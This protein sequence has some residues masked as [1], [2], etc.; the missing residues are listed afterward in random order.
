MVRVRV[1]LAILGV[2]SA[3][4]LAGCSGAEDAA[5]SA[6]EQTGTSAV[7]ATPLAVTALAPPPDSTEQVPTT[8]APPTTTLTDVQFE[9]NESYYFTTPDGNFQCAVIKLPTRIEAGCEGV[10]TPVPPRPDSCMINWGNAIRVTD[11]DDV[12]FMCSGG[13][14]YTSGGPSADPVLA[15]GQPLS[16]LGFTCTTTATDVSCVNDQTARGFRVAADSNEVF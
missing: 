3:V 4:I 6:P 9:R 12:G 1:G 7:S 5:Q 13:E 2:G 16:K 14:L 11:G 15:A 8:I 10:T